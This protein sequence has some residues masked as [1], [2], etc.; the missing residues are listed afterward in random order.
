MIHGPAELSQTEYL[1]QPTQADILDASEE[2]Y[3]RLAA[4]Y[5]RDIG[6]A[7][8][9]GLCD[10]ASRFMVRFLGEKGHQAARV[11]RSMPVLHFYVDLA[12]EVDEGERVLVDP[13]WQQFLDEAAVDPQMPKVLMGVRDEIVAAA[14]GHG[15]PGRFLDL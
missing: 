13:T 7:H 4:V 5:K 11:P 6:V 9:D 12:S 2:T 15:V 3:A 10:P 14:R 8:R 1:S